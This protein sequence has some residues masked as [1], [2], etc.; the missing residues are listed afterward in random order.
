MLSWDIGAGSRL[1]VADLSAGYGRISGSETGVWDWGLGIRV[2]IKA[3]INA[4]NCYVLDLEKGEKTL[5]LYKG[6]GK[7]SRVQ[8]R[9]IYRFSKGLSV[10]R[11][12]LHSGIETDRSGTMTVPYF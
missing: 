10:H 2:P 3:F 7:L 1:L 8:S 9:L 11:A 6:E 5:L 4:T 12:G